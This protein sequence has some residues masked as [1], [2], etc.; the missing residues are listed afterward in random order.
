MNPTGLPTMSLPAGLPSGLPSGLIDALV[1]GAV[2]AG[3]F[4]VFR[5]LLPHVNRSVGG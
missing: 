4:L 1:F 2:L 5:L 3:I